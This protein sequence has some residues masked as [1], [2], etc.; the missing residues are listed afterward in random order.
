MTDQD[1]VT[2]QVSSTI[3]ITNED[4]SSIDPAEMG[5]PVS[6]KWNVV[7]EDGN[8]VTTF[9]FRGE[10]AIGKT[11][12]I[13]PLYWSNLFDHMV[14]SQ[15]ELVNY[16]IDED[17]AK[18]FNVVNA[19]TTDDLKLLLTPDLN[20]DGLKMVKDEATDTYVL[21]IRLQIVPNYQK[22]VVHFVDRAGNTIRPDEVQWL[23]FGEASKTTDFNIEGADLY[24]IQT[25]GTQYYQP[26]RVVFDIHN[27]TI[28]TDGWDNHY[29]FTFDNF[30]IETY[31][32]QGARGNITE[33][34]LF[35][36]LDAP[37]EPIETRALYDTLGMTRAEFYAKVLNDWTYDLDAVWGPGYVDDWRTDNPYLTSESKEVNTQYND[38]LAL[39]ATWKNI[40]TYEVTAR[41]DVHQEP[42]VD[43]ATLIVHYIDEGNSIRRYNQKWAYWRVYR[44]LKRRLAIIRLKK[45]TGR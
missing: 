42:A 20:Y 43:E 25:D 26:N 11:P 5:K 16:W 17:E 34:N 27:K 31:Y 24:E 37:T 14:T 29:D 3:H 2:R 13:Q 33:S 9:T 1:S 19:Y 41:Y 45:R 7:D 44:D 39:Y 12:K 38:A 32:V 40:H 30:P 23:I 4:V 18:P 15:A 10:Y 35:I 6:I 36:N 28:T 22:T 8:P 21:E